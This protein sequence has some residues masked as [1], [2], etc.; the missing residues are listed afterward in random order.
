MFT[1]ITAAENLP[2]T[3]ALTVMFGIAIL[4]GITTLFGAGISNVIEAMLPD[5]DID[6]DVDLD[7]SEA[8]AP[9]PLSKLLG[10]L[11]IGQV[12]ILMLFV[13]FLTA[14]GLVGLGIQSVFLD[15]FGH[16][17]P[18]WIAVIPSF[19]VT[20]PIVRTCGGVLEKVMPRDETESV[21]SDSFIG[22]MATITLGTAKKGSAA[23]AK[24]RDEHGYTHYVMIEPDLDGEEFA[25]NQE[26]LIVKKQGS[27]FIAI[28]NT[29]DTLNSKYQ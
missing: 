8:Q 21:S 14:F 16:L 19:L 1:F 27:V 15:F 11:R 3:V 24:L 25:Q 17:L 2:F 10:W 6:I 13:I 5:I 9:T 7:G 23:Q 29:N 4:E 26:I 20:L 18:A 28:R 12:P 22:R